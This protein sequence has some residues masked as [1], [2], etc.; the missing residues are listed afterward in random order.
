MKGPGSDLRGEVKYKKMRRKTA[1]ASINAPALVVRV[2]NVML[3]GDG[4]MFVA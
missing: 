2:A 1:S 3:K 4:A